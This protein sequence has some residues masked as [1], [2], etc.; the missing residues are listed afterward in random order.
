MAYLKRTVEDAKYRTTCDIG[1]KI[2]KD[3]EKARL[4]AQAESTQVQLSTSEKVNELVK[5]AT[6]PLLKRIHALEK[7]SR[8]SGNSGTGNSGK[9]KRSNGKGKRSN[10]DGNA[11]GNG[12]GKGNSKGRN[13]GT[14]K[15]DGV[16][17]TTA[18]GPQQ[19]QQHRRQK[20][21]SDASQA[22]GQRNDG[23][24]GKRPSKGASKNSTAAADKPKSSK[25]RRQRRN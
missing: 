9:G 21:A 15:N 1:V 12:K 4:K 14:S 18:S 2:T 5:R 16:R 23:S 8:N 13:T 25:P 11:N 10:G 17:K 24:A 22:Q 3:R 19:G 20:N 7:Q 6:V